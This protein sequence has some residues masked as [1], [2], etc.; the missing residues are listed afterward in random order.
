MT[1]DTATLNHLIEVLNDGKKFYEEASA[2]VQRPD[3]KT[4]FAQ[5]ATTKGAIASDLKTA[6]SAK[7]PGKTPSDDDGTFVGSIR[8]AYSE[9]RTK[10]STDKNYAYIA[11]LESFED[12]IVAAFRD[13]AE[14]SDDMGIRTIAQRYLPQV[15][16]DHA[17]MRDMKHAR[18]A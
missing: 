12:R 8:K 7:D 18:A 11:E 10:L 9:I 6:V 13:A 4:L 14:K 5:M 15:L 16:R 3:L 2:H 1:N 17:Q